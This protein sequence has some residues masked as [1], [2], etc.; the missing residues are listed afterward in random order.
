MLFCNYANAGWH[1][2]T[3][4]GSTVLTFCTIQ[5]SPTPPPTN[6]PTHH[7]KQSGKDPPTHRLL[8]LQAHSSTHLPNLLTNLTT[9][10]KTQP[11][12]PNNSGKASPCPW[13]SPAWSYSRAEA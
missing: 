7:T 2:A 13:L 9:Y 4:G 11:I 12:H 1:V 10:A 5:V 6:P 8:L 3:L